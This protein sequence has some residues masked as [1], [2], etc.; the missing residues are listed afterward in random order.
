M[1]FAVATRKMANQNSRSMLFSQRLDKFR[2]FLRS[3][4]FWMSFHVWAEITGSR[5]ADGTGGAAWA[6]HLR[7]CQTR[8]LQCVSGSIAHGMFGTLSSN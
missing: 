2:S 7:K 6:K 1:P 3:L 5:G 8:A 4:A